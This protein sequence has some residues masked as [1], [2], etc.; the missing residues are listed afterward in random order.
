MRTVVINNYKEQE[1]ASEALRNLERCSD[2]QLE[3]ID[4]RTKNLTDTVKNESPDALILTGSN[5][6]LSK[7]DTQTVFHEEMEMVKDLN[8]PILGICFGH[9]LIGKEF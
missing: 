8:V 6:M 4:Y 9:Q 3:M 5:Y 2:Q 7:L 1:K